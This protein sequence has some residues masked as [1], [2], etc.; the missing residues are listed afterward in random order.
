[1]PCSARRPL[2]LLLALVVLAGI[3]VAAT[4]PWLLQRRIEVGMTEQQAEEVMGKPG[5]R[6][7]FTADMDVKDFC[8]SMQ[9]PC[10]PGVY[11]VRW[12]WPEYAVHVLFDCDGRVVEVYQPRYTIDHFL[13]RVVHAFRQR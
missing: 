7:P 1:M 4:L 12:E 3:G 10:P 8:R 9:W 13:G 11:V 5:F 6:V 2:L